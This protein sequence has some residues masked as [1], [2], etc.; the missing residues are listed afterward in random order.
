MCALL[1]SSIMIYRLAKQDTIDPAVYMPLLNTIAKGESSG[2]YNAYFGNSANTSIRF[3]D[4]TV[5]DVLQWQEDYARQGNV[6]NAVGKYQ[7][8]RPTLIGLVNQLKIDQ[9]EKFNEA[10]QDKM[11]IALLERRGAVEYVNKK[12]TREQFAANLAKEW[13]A[14]PKITEPNPHYS[15]YSA[16]GV[17]KSRITI[18]EVYGALG[19]LQSSVKHTDSKHRF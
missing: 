6:S 16:D 15:Y 7:I 1:L 12:L 18:D 2:N 8:I 13:A 5:S 10:L 3:T 11:A 14:L 4:M 19:G 9:N 17:N